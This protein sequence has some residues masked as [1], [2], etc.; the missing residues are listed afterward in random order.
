MTTFQG[1]VDERS[2]KITTTKIRKRHSLQRSVPRVLCYKNTQGETQIL[3]VC[4]TPGR[5]L[6]KNTNQ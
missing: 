3:L 1:I 4:K 6:K 2:S 5:G